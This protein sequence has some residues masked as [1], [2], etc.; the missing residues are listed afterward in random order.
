MNA[1][2]QQWE[3]KWISSCLLKIKWDLVGQ[4]NIEGEQGWECFAIISEGDKLTAWLKR[5][6]KTS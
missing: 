6:K 5:P 2:V 1:E 4:L 3:Y